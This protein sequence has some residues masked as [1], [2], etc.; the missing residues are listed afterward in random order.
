MSRHSLE[1]LHRVAREAGVSTE[2]LSEHVAR[3]LCAEFRR[4]RSENLS[5]GEAVERANHRLNIL[6]GLTP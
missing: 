1:A 6:E 2:Q 4:L 5:L 3:D